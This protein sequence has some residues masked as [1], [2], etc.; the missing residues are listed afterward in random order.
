MLFVGI[1]HRW[2]LLQPRRPLVSGMP[3]S[4]IYPDTDSDSGKNALATGYTTDE[5][6]EFQSAHG[7]TSESSGGYADSAGLVYRS[8]SER[9]ASDEDPVEKSK[10]SMLKSGVTILTKE[11]QERQ[12]MQARADAAAAKRAAEE[13]RDVKLST[14]FPGLPE[15]PINSEP[16]FAIFRFF[17]GFP[18]GGLDINRLKVLEQLLDDYDAAPTAES[19]GGA[20]GSSN[21]P[22]R[23]RTPAQTPGVGEM[24]ADGLQSLL[25]GVAGGAA[26]SGNSS[27][28]HP[29]ATEPYK[30]AASSPNKKS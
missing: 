12:R 9:A 6:V 8:M 22:G 4:W 20:A 19:T 23:S 1:L 21:S 13:P 18:V 17:R 26:S 30:Y 2:I 14:G 11:E 27:T 24:V 29:A 7:G 25:S 15:L 5:V 28:L 10:N 16:M 3:E